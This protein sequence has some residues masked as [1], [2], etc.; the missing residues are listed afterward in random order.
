MAPCFR[1]INMKVVSFQNHVSPS[2]ICV[3][4]RREWAFAG[5]EEGVKLEGQGLALV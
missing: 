3:L 5:E 4:T 1:D 2:W